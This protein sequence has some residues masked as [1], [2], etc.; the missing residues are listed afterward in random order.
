MY[1]ALKYKY[2]NITEEPIG[3][4]GQPSASLIAPGGTEYTRDT[5][6]SASYAG[7]EEIDEKLVSDLNPGIAVTTVDVF[8]VSKEKISENGWKIVFDTDP[9]VEVPLHKKE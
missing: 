2:K 6:A 1:V 4:F 5:G 9:R 3:M 7:E 8:E